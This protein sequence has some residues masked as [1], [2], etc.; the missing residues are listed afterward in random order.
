[1][2]M[3]VIIFLFAAAISIVACFGSSRSPKHRD[4]IAAAGAPMLVD[5]VRL[6]RLAPATSSEVATALAVVPLPLYRWGLSWDHPTQ[7]VSSV[8]FNIYGSANLLNVRSTVLT[9]V[10][11][12]ARTA[13]LFTT[14]PAFFFTMSTQF[15]N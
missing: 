14:T 15:T 1:M 11:G 8:S 13:V 10:P 12:S 4:Q 7:Y 9:N 5:P 2:R 6:A 3:S